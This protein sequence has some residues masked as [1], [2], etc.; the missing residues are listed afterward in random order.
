MIDSVAALLALD[1]AWSLRVRDRLDD[2]PPD[3]VALVLHLGTTPAWWNHK[4]AVSGEWKRQVKAHLKTAEADSLV[5]D[6]VRELARD[7]SF[8]EETAQVLA[9]RANSLLDPQTRAAVRSRTKGLAVGFL[10]A[11]GQLRTDDGVGTDL[12]LVARKNSQAMDVWYLPDSALAGA[13]FAALGDLTGPDTME[14]LWALYDAVPT[15]TPARPTLVRAVKRA[16]K[17]RRIPAEDLAERTVPRHGLERDGT[18]R[19]GPPGT[20]AEWAN[21]WTDTLT[22]LGA[23]GRVTLTWLD[24]ADGPVPTRAPFPLP[25]RYATPDLAD[26]ITIARNDARRIEATAADETRRLTD[27]AMTTRS[28]PWSEWA[29]YYRDHPI[30]GI[31]TRRLTWEYRLPGE[32][33]P[34]P[35]DPGT[36]TDAIPADAEVTLV[37][38]RLAAVSLPGLASTD[39]V[40]G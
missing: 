24:A 2:L 20:G 6:A 29:R 32:T 14:H 13:A 17:R 23:D 15:S 4:H 28:W 9:H 25:P 26:S 40:V 7:G 19:M 34:R 8:H 1:N 3:L 16:A 31:V 39:T 5:R 22:T 30:T 11:A 37:S 21:S 10:L 12:A 33:A 35:L 27:P 18:L 36:P 38:T